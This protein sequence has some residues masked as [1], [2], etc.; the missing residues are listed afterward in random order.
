MFMKNGKINLEELQVESFVTSLNPEEQATQKGGTGPA[1]L[2]ATGT[3][4]FSALSL[5]SLICVTTL[6]YVAF[7]AVYD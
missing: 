1:A 6:S 7:E 5:A 4:V 2:S 3:I